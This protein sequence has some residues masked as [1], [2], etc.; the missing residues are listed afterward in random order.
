MRAGASDTASLFQAEAARLCRAMSSIAS[1]TGGGASARMPA[2]TWV[3]SAGLEP[4]ST[5]RKPVASSCGES[6]ARIC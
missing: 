1:N 4:V 5:Q 3:R 6:E 2:I